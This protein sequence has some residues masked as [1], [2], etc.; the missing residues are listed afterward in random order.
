MRATHQE[1]SSTFACT[2]CPA[3]AAPLGG[4]VQDEAVVA[5]RVPLRA[6]RPPNEGDHGAI[7]LDIMLD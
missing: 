1:G 2:G 6:L 7:M 4:R 5:E 3:A